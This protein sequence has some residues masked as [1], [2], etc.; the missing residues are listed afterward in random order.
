MVVV[1]A[2]VVVVYDSIMCL[3]SVLWHCWLGIIKNI[4][5]V[6]NWVLTC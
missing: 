5:P 1:V 6:R 2:L 4:R 3:A